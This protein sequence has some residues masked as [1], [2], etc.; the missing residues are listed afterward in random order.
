MDSSYLDGGSGSTP[1]RGGK[2]LFSNK[3]YSCNCTHFSGCTSSNSLCDSCNHSVNSHKISGYI[4]FTPTLSPPSSNSA[5]Q[6]PAEWTSNRKLNAEEVSQ[7]LATMFTRNI[8]PTQSGPPQRESGNSRFA[9]AKRPKV[10]SY[11]TPHKA[12]S[13]PPIKEEIELELFLLL[14]YE[15]A[16]DAN[17]M[18]VRTRLEVDHQLLKRFPFRSQIMS[19]QIF[20]DDYLCNPSCLISGDFIQAGR[21]GFGFYL[22]KGRKQPIFARFHF[23][24]FPTRQDWENFAA[25]CNPNARKNKTRTCLVVCPNRPTTTSEVVDICERGESPN[26]QDGL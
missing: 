6:Q 10:N 22:Q 20:Y 9:S 12:A 25:D 7:E 15:Q 4:S 11:S 3:S 23:S 2:C 13:P 24:K 16:P 21:N 14:N 8:P 26:L 19:P 5:Q 17:E 1:V 18:T